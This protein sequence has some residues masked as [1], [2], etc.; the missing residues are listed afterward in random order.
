MNNFFK[1]HLDPDT[2]GGG[3]GSSDDGLGVFASAESMMDANISFINDNKEQSPDTDSSGNDEAGE[4]KDTV[5][6]DTAAT[7]DSKDGEDSENTEKQD[8]ETTADDKENG[9]ESEEKASKETWSEDHQKVL[10]KFDNKDLPFTEKN[11]KMVESYMD[12]EKRLTQSA[13]EVSDKNGMMAHMAKALQSGDVQTLQDLAKTM[14]SELPIETRT[15]EDRIKEIEG[16]YNRSFDAVAPVRDNIQKSVQQ[17]LANPDSFTVAQLAQHMEKLGE[18]LDSGLLNMQNDATSKKS[19][20]EQRKLIDARV[21]KIAGISP[22]KLNNPYEN[23]S[24]RAENTFTTLRKVD[25][26][27]DEAFDALKE[28]M[29][30]KSSFEA[31]GIPMAKLF[32]FSEHLAQD[33]FRMGKG[34]ALLKEFESGALKESLYKQWQK[35]ADGSDTPPPRGSGDV[36][37]GHE[38]A[39]QS[40]GFNKLSEEFMRTGRV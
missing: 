26:K 35:E 7:G 22:D 24:K 38:V 31:A 23:W 36:L 39:G 34:L 4:G 40:K 29:G 2:E 37:G 27:A 9:S 6:D 32:G 12:S 30:E 20:I 1:R 21:S 25:P 15:D 13:Q 8:Q 28:I 3:G 5:L 14:G 16:E 33:A 17:I 18:A 10:E 19:E 11:Q